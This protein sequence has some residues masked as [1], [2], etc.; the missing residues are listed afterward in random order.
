MSLDVI[1]GLYSFKCSSPVNVPMVL[2]ALCVVG[3]LM[4]YNYT[5]VEETRRLYQETLCQQTG[6][7]SANIT[8]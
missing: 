2:K 3:E 8:I 6:R 7:S 5:F 1:D 4:E